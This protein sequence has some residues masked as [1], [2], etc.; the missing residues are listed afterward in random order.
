MEMLICN[1]LEETAGNHLQ[2]GDN[3]ADGSQPLPFTRYNTVASCCAESSHLLLI[4][5]KLNGSHWF[6]FTDEQTEAQRS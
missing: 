2:D 6:P 4:A 3:I 5:A 1:E